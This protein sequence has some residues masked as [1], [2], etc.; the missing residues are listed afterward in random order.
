MVL[1]PNPIRIN[2]RQEEVMAA[3]FRA[4]GL[5]PEALAIEAVKF[6]EELLTFLN[7]QKVLK[8]G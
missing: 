5:D 4:R 3:A 6:L 8:L 2:E 7:Q 1:E